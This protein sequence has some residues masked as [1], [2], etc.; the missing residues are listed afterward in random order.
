MNG[1]SSQIRKFYHIFIAMVL[2]QKYSFSINIFGVNLMNK[3]SLSLTTRAMHW[4]V[5]I[6]MIG[7]IG[8]GFYMANWEVW[9]LYP[10]H[11]ALG[12]L[13]LFAVLPR[14]IYRIKQGFLT[15]NE[16][17]SETINTAIYYAHW[18]LLLGT[19]LMPVSGMLYSGFSGHGI[20]VFGVTLVPSN[21]VDN[22][23]VPF[24][25][26]IYVIAKAAHSVIAY[27]LTGLI[28]LHILGAFKHHVINKDSTLLRMLGRA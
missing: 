19:V 1:G 15:P 3:P 11:K 10:I 13:A 12:V 14:A 25:E 7:L 20:D 26:A 24:N 9:A 22:A 21:Y 2:K 5:A 4:L 16:G 27:T 23:A 8:V 6:I 18:G 17:A 28:G